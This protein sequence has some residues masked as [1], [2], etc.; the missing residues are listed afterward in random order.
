MEEKVKP[1]H[2]VWALCIFI[3]GAAFV[4]ASINFA[5]MDFSIHMDNNTKEAIQSLN[6]SFATL[7]NRTNE[8]ENTN[9]ALK[10]ELA[11]CNESL[12][13]LRANPQTKEVN[14]YV[15][16]RSGDV[17]TGY[18]VP[19]QVYY[20]TLNNRQIID[21]YYIEIT[22]GNSDTN[23]ISL[24]VNGV[25]KNIAKGETVLYLPDLVV[26]AEDT[27]VINIPVL[28]ASAYLSIKRLSHPP[29]TPNGG[30]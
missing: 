18:K 29:Q 3:L 22:G 28:D 6:S 16:F 12:N 26:T 30:E 5:N 23:S 15:T 13:Y 11:V 21:S 17:Y 25:T 8:I 7:D 24:S 20:L 14:R 19:E 2:A 9:F 10:G 4:L 27:F 1:K